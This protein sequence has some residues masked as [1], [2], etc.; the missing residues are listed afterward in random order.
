MLF[1]VALANFQQKDSP[2]W[3]LAS[4]L[5]LSSLPMDPAAQEGPS[6]RSSTFTFSNRLRF[7]SGFNL[8]KPFLVLPPWLNADRRTRTRI[9][10]M[11]GRD[12]FW[13]WNSFNAWLTLSTYTVLF[14]YFSA[15]VLLVCIKIRVLVLTG[16]WIPDFFLHIAYNIVLHEK[17]TQV[18]KFSLTSEMVI[19]C[20]IVLKGP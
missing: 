10:M 4:P 7:H 20:I 9:Q 2:Y 5:L 6:D 12:F 14:F 11:G 8:L 1:L 3:L 15:L 13:S 18:L 16:N 17:S 19:I